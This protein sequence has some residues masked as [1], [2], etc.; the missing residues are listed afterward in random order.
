MRTGIEPKMFPVL[1]ADKQQIERMGM[2]VTGQLNVKGR[3][4]TWGHAGDHASEV[5]QWGVRVGRRHGNRQTD[6]Q[7]APRSCPQTRSKSSPPSGRLPGAGSNPRP[8]PGGPAEIHVVHL[9]GAVSGDKLSAGRGEISAAPIR[10]NRGPIVMHAQRLVAVFILEIRI[11]DDVQ[12]TPNPPRGL[13]A[14]RRSS[15]PLRC[16]G[17]HR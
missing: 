5:L 17:L 10:Q 14:C 16:L 6:V 8:R 2:A 15:G 13:P 11:D 9:R 1:V 7:S 4:L 3:R 12:Q